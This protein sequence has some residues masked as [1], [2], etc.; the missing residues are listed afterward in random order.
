MGIALNI[1]FSSEPPV[2]IQAFLTQ[3]GS[4]FS[5]T[6]LFTIG[7][8]MV[9]RTAATTTDTNSGTPKASR[10]E[11]RSGVLTSRS[12]EAGSDSGSTVLGTHTAAMLRPTRTVGTREGGGSS[13]T[14]RDIDGGTNGDIV[15]SSREG[16]EGQGGKGGESKDGY[17]EI[18]ILT[19]LKCVL[20]PITAYQATLL[21]SDGDDSTALLALIYGCTPTATA[22]YL[23]AEQYQARARTIGRGTVICTLLS[24]PILYLSTLIVGSPAANATIQTSQLQDMGYLVSAFSVVGSSVLLLAVLRLLFVHGEYR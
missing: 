11:V 19:L 10:S 22:V 2:Y 24:A 3:V 13:T 14:T 5:A 6:A 18:V 16:T 20:V 21:L 9:P 4:A 7:L 23:F 8:S 15:C 17:L 12:E 1:V